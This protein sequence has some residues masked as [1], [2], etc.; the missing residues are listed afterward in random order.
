VAQ[1]IQVIAQTGPLPIQ[2]TVQIE[3]D[4]PTIVTIAGSVWSVDEAYEV[5]ILLS[6]D[7][8]QVQGAPIF[9]NAGQMHLAVV[10]VTFSYTFPWTETQEHVFEL[11]KLTGETM[12]DQ[13]DFFVVTVQY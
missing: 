6:I 13:N 1:L 3:T 9:A 8:D 5:G 7:G 12:T 2:Q 11:D 10:P 4:A